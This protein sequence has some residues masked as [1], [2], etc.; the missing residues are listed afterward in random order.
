MEKHKANT[1]CLKYNH[2]KLILMFI[3]ISALFATLAFAHPGKTDIN[4]GHK[5]SNTGEYH[6]HHGHEAHFHIDG[7]CPFEFDD[8]TGQSSGSTSTGGNSGPSSNWETT[9]KEV[10]PETKESSPNETSTTLSDNQPLSKKKTSEVDSGEI[11]GLTL[12]SLAFIFVFFVIPIINIKKYEA[13]SLSCL[14]PTTNNIVNQAKEE[15]Q[16]IYIPQTIVPRVLPSVARDNRENYWKLKYQY[17]RK[18]CLY[19]SSASRVMGMEN[20]IIT[21]KREPENTYDRHAIAVYRKKER[22][23]Y[24][25][26]G[27]TQAMMNEWLNRKYILIGFIKSVY[28]HS[29]NVTINIAFYEPTTPPNT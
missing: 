21:F 1:C 18:L 16:T 11:V 13:K 15:K 6:Y 26:K 25:Y 9:S 3:M 5:N 28:P 27:E 4:G 19:G 14:P 8:K 10:K 29:N 23:G 7:Q 12:L 20:K 22:I 17:E 2:I 24:I